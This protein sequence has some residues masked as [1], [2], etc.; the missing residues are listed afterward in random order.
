MIITKK[1]LA[2]RTFLR[3]VGTALALPLLDS[4]IPAMAATRLTPA[5]PVS[6]S[7]SCYVPNGIIQKDWVPTADGRGLR[8]HADHEVARALPR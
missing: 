4:M 1:A 3:G 6:V 2:R 7:G 8:V 5:N